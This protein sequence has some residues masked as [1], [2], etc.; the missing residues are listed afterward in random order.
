MKG[1][2]VKDAIASESQVHKPVVPGETIEL[3][4]KRM[5]FVALDRLKC[6]AG[7]RWGEL[8]EQLGGMQA[9]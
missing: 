6:A 2:Y 9:V 7:C 8:A 3:K 4:F 5:Q 1:G